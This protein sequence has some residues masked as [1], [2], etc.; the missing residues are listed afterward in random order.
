MIE[1]RLV[2][3]CAFWV[4]TYIDSWSTACAWTNL[5]TYFKR[6]TDWIAQYSFISFVL[7]VCGFCTSVCFSS[8]IVGCW[9]SMFMRV[10]APS[11][12]TTPKPRLFGFFFS[13]IYPYPC[14]TLVLNSIRVSP[15]VFPFLGF[16][17]P[18]SVFLKDYPRDPNDTCSDAVKQRQWQ[19]GSG[20]CHIDFF[21]GRRTCSDMSEAMRPGVT[22]HLPTD[23][24]SMAARRGSQLV[25]RRRE[26]TQLVDPP[27]K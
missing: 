5:L 2:Q 1:L 4:R 19:R 24:A 26:G 3:H 17:E 7:C 16:L 25:I 10:Q 8:R 14:I 11:T 15:W 22:L 21:Q 13:V 12:K 23:A 9:N 18:Y 27:A 20:S 6:Y